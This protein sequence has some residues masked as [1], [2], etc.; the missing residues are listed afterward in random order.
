MIAPTTAASNLE[1]NLK[2]FAGGKG[3]DRADS[4]PSEFA[5]ALQR[6]S[7]RASTSDPKAKTD[8]ANPP[9]RSDKAPESTDQAQPKA[10]ES[11][12]EAQNQPDQTSDRQ[13]E[14]R[15]EGQGAEP[16]S[17]KDRKQESAADAV[18]QSPSTKADT[19]P[20]ASPT[21]QLTSNNAVAAVNTSKNSN[22]Q[23]ES[24]SST[25]TSTASGSPDGRVEASSQSAGAPPSS[26]LV[27]TPSGGVPVA[28]GAA[29]GDPSQSQPTPGSA[30][31]AQQEA[32]KQ[33]SAGPQPVDQTNLP[34][35]K[36]G[37]SSKSQKHEEVNSA[38]S[39][40]DAQAP[41]KGAR[42]NPV[43]SAAPTQDAVLGQGGQRPVDSLTAPMRQSAPASSA[44][45]ADPAAGER[46]FASTVSR[47]L[48]AA[49]RHNGGSVTIR[50]KP[51]SLGALRIDLSIEQGVVSAQF[52][53]TTDQAR[54]LLS[55]HLAALRSSLEA[56]GFGVHNVDILVQA[57]A[58][59]GDASNDFGRSPQ[60][61]PG[62]SP[63]DHPGADAQGQPHTRRED[64]GGVSYS[65]QSVDPFAEDERIDTGWR[66]VR[67][68]GINTIA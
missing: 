18:D 33:G 67:A 56:K 14:A 45:L 41:V 1:P 23:G 46:L 59:T 25:S 47:G 53:V 66:P 11:A 26:A 24:R 65:N 5:K 2:A 32:L 12:D 37:D 64:P 22:T 54:G 13:D 61:A 16:R 36:K 19:P 58:R 57:S 40:S 34:A 42:V 30:S 55:K 51:E 63:A 15:V 27:D 68:G 17:E 49:L 39:P 35:D 8:P 52:Q 43:E 10:V 38:P 21:D 20:A 7:D 48:E 28:A 3:V 31:D 60:D 6:R 62:R 29:L 44:D 4:S 50:L 9:E